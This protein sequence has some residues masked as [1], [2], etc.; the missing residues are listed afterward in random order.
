MPIDAAALTHQPGLFRVRD[1]IIC[2]LIDEPN[3]NDEKYANLLNARAGE[4]VSVMK[5]SETD[6]T[7]LHNLVAFY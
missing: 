7:K 5:V 4:A 1:Y 6:E 3:L 2:I